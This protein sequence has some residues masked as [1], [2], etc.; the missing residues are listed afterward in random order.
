MIVTAIPKAAMITAVARHTGCP[1]ELGGLSVAVGDLA[2]DVVL[3][4]SVRNEVA[5]LSQA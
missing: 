4:L 1:C 5:D 2:D 3:P